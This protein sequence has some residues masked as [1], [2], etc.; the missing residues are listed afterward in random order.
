MP[1]LHTRG[2]GDHQKTRERLEPAAA[3]GH[4][5]PPSVCGP[6]RTR[7]ADIVVVSDAL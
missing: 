7:T 3:V 2:E 6:G 5:F 4:Y 1:L